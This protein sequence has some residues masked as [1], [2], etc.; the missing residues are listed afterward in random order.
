MSAEQKSP[1]SDKLL[2]KFPPLKIVDQVYHPSNTLK[3]ACKPL[4]PRLALSGNMYPVDIST[5]F[6][7][8]ANS[9]GSPKPR[10][11]DS[12]I[13]DSGFNS[14]SLGHS[15][16]FINDNT[17]DVANEIEVNP[18]PFQPQNFKSST[19]M[20]MV[21]VPRRHDDMFNCKEKYYDKKK[22]VAFH[23]ERYGYLESI[24][25]I[26]RSPVELSQRERIL[27][28]TAHLE[29]IR[30]IKRQL[31]LS[32]PHRR[33]LNLQMGG[34]KIEFCDRVDIPA[35]LRELRGIVLPSHAMDLYIGKGIK[36]P[37]GHQLNIP[38]SQINPSCN[39]IH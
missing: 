10:A 30:G 8:E 1:P 35:E 17:D 11:T 18:L 20:R 5:D 7:P 12:I 14:Q 4:A 21:T 28:E 38:R 39:I 15:F 31:R 27:A 33:P 37:E 34:S 9:I 16:P 3:R 29:K 25:N 32:A 19:V 36:L 2:V 26:D 6:A 13:T 24:V 22:G 23:T